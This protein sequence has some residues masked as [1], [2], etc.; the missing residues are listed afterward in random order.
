MSLRDLLYD[1]WSK[2]GAVPPDAL[3][4]AR[5]NAHFATQVVAAAGFS[6]VKPEPDD[7]HTTVDWVDRLQAL[8]GEEIPGGLRV[9]LRI[10]DLRLMLLAKGGIELASMPLIGHTLEAGIDWLRGQLKDQ[11]SLEKAPTI[12]R[13]DYE[14]PSFAVAKGAKFDADT[15]KLGELARWYANA[16]ATL[17]FL[18]G[19]E[20]EASRV[21][22]WPH[23]FDVATLLTLDEERTIGIGM[24]PGDASYRQPYFYVTPW[25]YPKG[26]NLPPLT[27]GGTWHREGW[28]GAVLTASKLLAASSSDRQVETLVEFLNSALKGAREIQARS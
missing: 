22:C 17:Q 12:K 3:M 27:G 2:L 11:A 25:P 10:R 15:E 19:R 24:S 8:V 14:M 26:D 28:T 1:N 21:M 9:G 20:P 23:H 6:L 18:A 16:D 5:L 13:P 4:N 7:S